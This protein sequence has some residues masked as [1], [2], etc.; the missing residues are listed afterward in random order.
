MHILTLSRWSRTW[1][2]GLLQGRTEGEEGEVGGNEN[3]EG[4]GDGNK[5]V[6]EESK[7]EEVREDR[8]VNDA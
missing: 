6:R 4:N 2:R 1:R 3:K 7:N 8:K 5:M